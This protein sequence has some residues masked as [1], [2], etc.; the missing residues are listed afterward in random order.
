MLKKKLTFKTAI[1]AIAIAALL[2]YLNQPSLPKCDSSTIQRDMGTIM[3][4]L[5]FKG[6][7]NIY[8][9]SSDKTNGRLCKAAIATELGGLVTQYKV[10]WADADYNAFLQKERNYRVEVI[11]ES[12]VFD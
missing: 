4:E 12:V 6:M 1:G 3:A 2:M 8:E 5:G 7:S 9:V 10:Y 11:K